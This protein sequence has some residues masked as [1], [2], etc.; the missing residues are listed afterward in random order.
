[1]TEAVHSIAGLN[2][3]PL[4]ERLDYLRLMVPARLLDQF[5]INPSTFSDPNGKSL[6]VW[7]GKLGESDAEISLYR[8]TSDP[9]PLVYFHLTDTVSRQVH[10]LLAVVNDPDSPRFDTDRLPDGT[11][12][13]FGIFS[14]NLPAEVAAFEAGLVPGQIHRGLRMLREA[15]TAFETFAKRLGHDI[16]FIE[17]MHYHNAITFERYGFGYQQGKRWME[18]LNTRF[19][20]GGDLVSRLDDSTP[21]R[22]PQAA[23]SVRGR[24]WAIHD[25][26][27]GEPYTGVTMYKRVGQ[28][29]GV[30]TFPGSVW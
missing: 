22:A 9:D 6:L 30:Q 7:N 24:S 26:I 19:S 18:S 20:P 14:R 11:R 29:A 27:L 16:Y 10:I 12:T 17:P 3:L 21:F 23:H 15:M 1:M 28:Q 2:S 5:Q 13:E 8:R 4:A 25:G